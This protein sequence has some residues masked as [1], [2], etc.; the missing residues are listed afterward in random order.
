MPFNLDL[1][2]RITSQLTALAEVQFFL[3]LEIVG[4]RKIDRFNPINSDDSLLVFGLSRKRL[5]SAKYKVGFR[6]NPWFHTITANASNGSW[7]QPV[8]ATS[9]LNRSAGVS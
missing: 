3:Y 4:E 6:L 5:V 1:L 9:W 2:R 8:D 7:I